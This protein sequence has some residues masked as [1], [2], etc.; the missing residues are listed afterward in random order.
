MTEDEFE[1]H[2]AAKG[3]ITLPAPL[4]AEEFASE[5]AEFDAYEPIEVS[6]T[7]LSQMIIEER[8]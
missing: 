4:T 1:Q 3:I 8:R 7:P 5:Q 2:L 6:G